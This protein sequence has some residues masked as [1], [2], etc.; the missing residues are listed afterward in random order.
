MKF[1]VSYDE[2]KNVA[3][4]YKKTDAIYGQKNDNLCRFGS[5]NFDVKDD[6]RSGRLTA[7]KADDIF[8]N[9]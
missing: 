1:A 6:P 8:A 5:G 7:K 4:T 9:V 2:E 3:Q